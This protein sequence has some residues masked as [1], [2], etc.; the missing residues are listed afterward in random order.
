MHT[1][2]HRTQQLKFY[3]AILAMAALVATVLAVAMAGGAQAQSETYADPH[4]CGPG[5][6]EFY[7]LPEFPVDQ[8]SAGHYAIFDAYYD[9]DADQPHR[10]TE[11]D[12]PW[13]GLMS[14]NFCPPTVE[15]GDDGLENVTTTRHGTN[16]DIDRT[17]VHVDQTAHTL[18]AAEVAAYPDLGDAGDEVYWLR[19]GDDPNTPSATE[20]ASDLQLSFSTALFDSIHWYREDEEGNSVEPFWYE[21]EAE[22]ELG[23]HPRE[24]GHIYLFDN[25]LAPENETKKPIWNSALSDTGRIDMWPGRYEGLQWVFTK[26]G[27]YELS[28]HINAHVR[29]DRPDDLPDDEVWHPASEERL[30]TSE[31]KQYIFQVGS[32]SLNEQP[33][34]RA[35][36]SSV[37]ENS[38]AG[39]LVG[40]PVPVFQADSDALTYELTG[41]GSGNFEVESTAQ[42]GQI[43]VAAGAHLDYEA[44]QSYQL[45]LAVSDDKD[46]E[47]NPDG[48]VDHTIAVHIAVTDVADGPPPTA[49]LSVNP[50]TQSHSGSVTF[51]NTIDDLP[52]GAHSLYYT[53]WVLGSN[54]NRSWVQAG[55]SSSNFTVG[56]PYSAKTV[57]YQM[58]VQYN[59]PHHPEI[60][61]YSNA[62]SVVWQ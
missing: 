22:R 48:S 18:T 17:V 39:T 21:I 7:P 50:T 51:T 23:L 15:V 45:V 57:S 33:M 20:Q 10:P 60:S 35:P 13:A 12:E 34:F 53:L 52:T 32:L 2:T 25:S 55:G 59:L 14:L 56:G 40:S 11:E 43:K 30:V 4:P 61:F 62:V 16:V 42:G 27:T 19:V 37:P 54:G 31:V 47:S 6:D 49:N 8:V 38:A 24:Y 44:V 9:L 46:R 58:E 41:H 5:F 29:R 36:D 28:V 26:P 3:G 1:I